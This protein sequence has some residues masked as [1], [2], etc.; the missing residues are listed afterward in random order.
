LAQP[1]GSRHLY[2]DDLRVVL[3]ILVVGPFLGTFTLLLNL[4][5]DM[6]TTDRVNPRKKYVQVIEELIGQGLMDRET[7]L[8][9]SFG[10]GAL[11]I[12]LAA[13][14]SGVLV[15]YPAPVGSGPL[16]AIGPHGFLAISVVLALLSVAYSHPKIRWK[17]VPGADLLTNMVGF[18]VLCPL[19][20]WALLR[21]IEESPTWFVLTIALFIGALYAP[22]TAS[23]YSADRAFGIRT[24]A[25]RLGIGPTLA[26]GFVLEVASVA[27]LAMGW[28]QRWF[29]FDGSAYD[30]MGPLWPFLVLAIVFYAV[31]IR[32]PSVGKIWSL[33]LVLSLA[34][35]LGVILM[36]WASVGGLALTT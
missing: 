6:G 33:I 1:A 13:Y 3:A 9:A 14:V 30:A 36:L 28:S 16:A 27:V 34:Q 7:L 19:A 17:G 26:M 25:V 12:L 18:G 29:P 20:G 21:P 4:Y 24:L 15:A 8:L 10:F 2:L 5:F 22:T 11:G 23:D 32:R 31:F 35:G